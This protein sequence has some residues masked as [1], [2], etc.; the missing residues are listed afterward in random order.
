MTYRIFHATGPGNLIRAHKHWAAGEHD[1]SEVSITFSSQFADFCRD[2][3]AEAYIIARHSEKA[4][5]RDGPFTLEHRPKPM[6]GAS[7]LRYHIAE[8]LYGLGLLLTAIRFRANVAVMDAG[9]SHNFIL[10]IFP[11]AGIKTI[12][13]L[14]TTLWASGFPPT[15]LVPRTIAKLDSLFFRW[16]PIATIGVSPECV[17][18]VEQLTRG[19][20]APLYQIRAQFRREYF[21]EIPPPPPHGQRPFRIMYI[22][23]INRIKG[24][25]DVLEMAKRI[26]RQAPG[27]VRWEMCGS[28]PDLDE[29]RR[30]QGEMGLKDVVSIRGWTSLE[31]LQGVYAR[32]H[33]SIVPTRSSFYE[34]LAM[35]AAEAILAGRPVITSP[36]VP[37]LEVLRPACVEAKTNDVDS[38]VKAILALIENPNQY[39]NLCEACPQLQAQFYDRSQ[40]LRIILKKIL[41]PK[42]PC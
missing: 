1:P 34:G 3:N 23:R 26:E 15:R 5:Y 17:R 8:V 21:Q 6:P 10:S 31:D 22:G 35:T 29:L 19:K 36:V 37:A 38:Y 12:V 16:L 41:S 32:S 20:H 25:F 28:G 33:V 14:H 13:V 27:R 42:L 24:V 30:L 40:G 11:L 39:R 7:G 18:Q 9:T 2:I 4:V